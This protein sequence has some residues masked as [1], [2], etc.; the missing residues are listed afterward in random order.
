[1]SEKKKWCWNNYTVLEQSKRSDKFN[2]INNENQIKNIKFTQD[3]LFIDNKQNIMRDTK[4]TTQ[5]LNERLPILQ[6]NGNPYMNN[7]YIH[8]LDQETEFLRPKNSNFEEQ[9]K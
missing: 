1:M 3:E 4:R 8:H 2:Y 7:D 5:S 6:K 9:Q